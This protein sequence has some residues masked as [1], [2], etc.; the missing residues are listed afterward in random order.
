MHTE[1]V[2][3]FDKFAKD[4]QGGALKSFATAYYPTIRMHLVRVRNFNVEQ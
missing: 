1:A 2:E 4:G 3:L